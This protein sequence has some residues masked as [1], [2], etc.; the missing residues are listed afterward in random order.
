MDDS[1]FG[2]SGDRLGYRAWGG[3][4]YRQHAYANVNAKDNG[5]TAGNVDFN[6]D[7][8]QSADAASTYCID[9]DG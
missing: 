2:R 7:V 3:S 4:H 5:D 1:D 6:A 8:D 9:A